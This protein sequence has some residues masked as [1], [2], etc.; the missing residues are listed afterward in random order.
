MTAQ[1]RAY[2]NLSKTTL[3]ARAVGVP[4]QRHV[5][6]LFVCLAISHRGRPGLFVRVAVCGTRQAHNLAAQMECAQDPPSK[7]ECD[8]IMRHLDT[9]KA[10]PLLDSSF[11]ETFMWLERLWYAREAAATCTIMHICFTAVSR[12]CCLSYF[13]PQIHCQAHDTNAYRYALHGLAKHAVQQQR[14][15]ILDQM[16][17]KFGIR[18]VD[19]AKYEDHEWGTSYLKL[20]ACRLRPVSLAWLLEQAPIESYKPLR[21]ASDLLR[22]A[23]DALPADDW[24]GY[25]ECFNDLQTVIRCL[26]KHG[27]DPST[28][29]G[30]SRTELN[31]AIRMDI[32]EIFLPVI[33]SHINAHGLASLKESV[34]PAEY[35]SCFNGRPPF[36]EAVLTGACNAM[37]ALIDRGLGVL[38][39]GYWNILEYVCQ[40][41]RNI[42][43]VFEILLAEGE[44]FDAFVP[45]HRIVDLPEQIAVRVLAASRRGRFDQQELAYA[46]LSS[47]KRGR[48]KV[49]RELLR[50]GLN[51]V[52][53]DSVKGSIMQL[54]SQP[55]VASGVT[56]LL[57]AYALPCTRQNVVHMRALFRTFLAI[58][59]AAK[60]A[61]PPLPP[62]IVWIILSYLDGA[63]LF[64]R[65]RGTTFAVGDM[66]DFAI[67]AFGS[68]ALKWR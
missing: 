52:W 25:P 50:L 11:C 1:L 19:G 30:L 61:T 33:D 56:E 12:D 39:D 6:G 32:P 16:R 21:T 2:W 67:G 48:A 5:G 64:P 53:Y 22:D 46:G 54:A 60:K 40:C 26:I 58:F 59:G 62:E 15:S 41:A 27:A 31:W 24:D 23:Y 49:L 68:A 20:A 13:H 51:P 3:H 36:C 66:R 63:D 42:H 29:F 17:D 43:Q 37:R 28:S 14:P 47:A 34:E 45:L 38:G 7:Q 8:E 55:H 65:I 18:F 4:L 10:K 35:D 57:C 44:R 9:I